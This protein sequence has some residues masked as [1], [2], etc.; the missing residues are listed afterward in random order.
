MAHRLAAPRGARQHE[1]PARPSDGG[2]IEPMI[3]PATPARG[4]AFH[5]WPPADHSRRPIGDGGRSGGPAATAPMSRSWWKWGHGAAGPVRRCQSR[6]AAVS[7]RGN[8]HAAAKRPGRPAASSGDTRSSADDAVTFPLVRRSWA[9][10][11]RASRRSDRGPTPRGR[12]TFL[13]AGVLPAPLARR[14]EGRRPRP[15]G[16]GRR[17]SGRRSKKTPP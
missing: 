2:T 16:S 8:C 15:G 4:A 12:V 14:G 11:R 6:S 3:G 10:G 9:A 1:E 17:R 13:G 7:C 5:A